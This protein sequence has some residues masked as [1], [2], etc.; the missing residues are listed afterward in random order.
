[1]NKKHLVSITSLLHSFQNSYIR[2]VQPTELASKVLV[3]L[4]F[5]YIRQTHLDLDYKNNKE[6]NRSV[7]Q[8][9]LY[10]MAVGYIMSVHQTIWLFKPLPTSV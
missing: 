9:I 10:G 6:N 1:M 3:V 8:P 5:C 7:Y 4:T 2:S